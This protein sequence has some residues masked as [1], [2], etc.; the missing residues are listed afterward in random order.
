MLGWLPN[1]AFDVEF[2]HVKIPSVSKRKGL[3]QVKTKSVKTKIKLQNRF[4]RLRKRKC[5]HFK[6]TYGS[7]DD[8]K[9]TEDWLE[10]QS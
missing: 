1:I 8:P 7:T 3:E 2:C 9:R 6:V 10:C 5:P 4:K